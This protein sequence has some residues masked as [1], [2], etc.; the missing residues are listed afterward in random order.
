MP[1]HVA[2]LGLEPASIG[3]QLKMIG[4][5]RADLLAF[6]TDDHAPLPSRG[7]TPV[8]AMI[9]SRSVIMTRLP[10]PVK[11]RDLRSSSASICALLA[12]SSLQ[13]VERLKGSGSSPRRRSGRFPGSGS[14]GW[15][16]RGRSAPR[17]PQKGPRTCAP[18]ACR[19]RRAFA[20]WRI[21]R[22][23]NRRVGG[24]GRHARANQHDMAAVAQ[25]RPAGFG[26]MG[27]GDDDSNQPIT[28]AKHRNCPRAGV[29][30][31]NIVS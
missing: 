11:S 4:R 30:V 13:W 24:P 17:A 7:E 31:P 25:Q 19:G 3:C 10:E 18:A 16:A 15:T 12:A 27:R 6:G 26:R 8:S 21:S 1:A 14:S 5:A 28:D 22:C 9:F 23:R 2:R 20:G 29:S